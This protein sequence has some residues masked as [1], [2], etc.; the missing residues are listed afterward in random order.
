MMEKRKSKRSRI[1]RIRTWIQS[2]RISRR[3]LSM[4]KKPSFWGLFAKYMTVGL[5]VAVLTG[6][7]GTKIAVLYY[8]TLK[9]QDFVMKTTGISDE[10]LLNYKE[11]MEKEL[12]KEDALSAW[13]ARIQWNSNMNSLLG[14]EVC[15]YDLHTKEVFVEPKCVANMIVIENPGT[16]N[17]VRHILECDWKEM[18]DAVS[19]YNNWFVE[20]G[21]EDD[22]L[23][24]DV[25][26]LEMNEI[27]IKGGC[28]I[29]GKIQLQID[30]SNGG[31]NVIKE[32]DYAPANTAGYRYINLQNDDYGTLGPVWFLKPDEDVRCKLVRECI[33]HE[34][35]SV[36]EEGIWTGNYRREHSTYWGVQIVDSEI[37]TVD[38]GK[39]Y[40][41][42]FA[43]DINLW[44]DYKEFVLAAYGGLFLF[45]LLAALAIAYRNYIKRLGYYQLDA[46]RRETTNAMAHDLK[47]PLMAISG[48]AENLR[49]NVHTEKKDRYA[50]LIV[51]HVEYMNQMVEK[52]LEL[53]KVE[54]IS[55]LTEKNP[56]DLNTL[57]EAV[58]KKYEIL[59]TDKNLQVKVEG[60]C[61]VEA[62]KAYMEQAA[63]N[64][65]GNAIK[66]A[67]EET[68]IQIRLEKEG[69]EIR[70]KINGQLQTPANRLW[71]P[72]VK[73][74]DSRNMQKGTGIGLTIVKNIADM[75]GFELE[76]QY[77]EGEFV[78][79]LIF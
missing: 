76:L 71:K 65:I 36:D 11:S 5:C 35:D 72:F 45:T 21:V 8:Q 18:E 20:N 43:A 77:E 79:K 14:Y 23:N 33:G 38:E 16:E 47:T 22:G 46:Y 4:M 58:L 69:Y 19:D 1:G 3:R 62:D 40:L 27:Y 25:P 67:P 75:H 41:L 52:I 24:V 57:T 17:K 60:V 70:N 31:I 56:V 29:P 12:K 39:D 49:E 28:F 7:G 37:I 53:A 50:D 9:N 10:I 64:L 2:R 32:Y 15:L 63:E 55:R 44:K 54:S 6:C 73:G 66:Y 61:V 34:G 78:A 51:E 68:E 26:W 42:I 74:D 48:Y 59:M 13:K 30:D